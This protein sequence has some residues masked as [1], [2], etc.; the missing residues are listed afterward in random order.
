MSDPKRLLDPT[1]G[2]DPE[3][4]VLLRIA[5]SEVP[6]HDQLERLEQQL[7]VA[8]AATLA[9]ASSAAATAAGG[10]AS[11]GALSVAAAVKIGA[12]A[13]VLVAA[14]GTATVAM[15]RAGPTTNPPSAAPALVRHS[16]LTAKPAELGPRQSARSA[17]G[18]ADAETPDLHAVRAAGSAMPAAEPTFYVL[19]PGRAADAALAFDTHPSALPESEVS[20]LQRASDA[21]A[22]APELALQLTDEDARDHPAGALAQEREFIAI[23]ALLRL[24]KRSEARVRAHQFLRDFPRSAHWPRI[25]ALVGQASEPPVHNSGHEGP[26]NR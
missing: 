4:R 11:K 13:T 24:G 10:A 14:A 25:E 21:V 18:T 17:T 7:S 19:E 20:L 6:D 2:A 15:H 8:L 22:A 23:Q 9:G 5:R 16:D 1:S 3:L 12:A 26:L